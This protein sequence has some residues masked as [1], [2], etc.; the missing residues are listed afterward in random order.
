MR[1]FCYYL[2]NWIKATISKPATTG[3]Q[4]GENT[5]HHDQLATAP[6]FANLRIRNTRKTIPNKPIPPDFSL[7]LIVENFIDCITILF[8]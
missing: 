1:A 2:N 4:K 3:I 7:V 6:T 5:H 8:I